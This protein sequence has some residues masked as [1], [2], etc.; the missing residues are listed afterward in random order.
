[1]DKNTYMHILKDVLT[2]KNDLL[3]KLINITELQ[4]EHI[5]QI[6]PDLET[7]NR[8][9]SDKEE[10]IQ[11]IN[12][13][14]EGFESIYSH[15]QSEIKV[16]PLGFKEQIETLQRLIHQIT[17]K[18]TKLQVMELNNKKMLEEFFLKKKIEIKN[19]KRSNK[20]VSNYYNTMYNQ[21]SGESYFLDKKK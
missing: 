4:L 7:F 5:N 6:N 2:R 16:K 21:K 20:M 17:D 1:M 3:D 8:T 18:S 9:L 14:D 13:L 15:V 19:F 10:Y 12:Q 11:Q